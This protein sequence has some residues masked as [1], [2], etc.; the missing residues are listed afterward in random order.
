MK[1]NDGFVLANGDFNNADSTALV[2]QQGNNLVGMTDN[3][4]QFITD[5]TSRSVS[6][7]SMKPKTEEESIVLFNAMNNP[8]KRIKDC[9]NEVISV[10]HIFVEVVYCEDKEHVGMKVPC[11]RIVLIDEKGTGYQAV[12]KGVY[13]AT[14]KMIDSFGLPETWDKPKKFKVRQISKSAEV[15]ILTFDAVLPVKK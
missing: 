1:Q 9:I 10:K 14:K 11:P 3:G 12:S 5:L 13:T 4:S 15:S 6:Y 8:E 7:C 2:V